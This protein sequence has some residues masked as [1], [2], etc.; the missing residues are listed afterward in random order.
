M[1]LV[2]SENIG[3]NQSELEIFVDANTFQNACRQAYLRQIKRLNIPGFRKGKAPKKVVEKLLG[4]QVFFESAIDMVYPK[5]VE[6]AIEEAGL[7]VVSL[8]KIEPI[9]MSEQDGLN[10]KATC[11]LKPEAEIEN[12]KGIEVEVEPAKEVDDVEVNKQIEILRERG[13]R[14]ISVSDRGAKEGDMVLIDY[15]GFIDGSKFKGGSAK[16][17][18]LKLGSKQFIEGFEK[19]IEGHKVGE[20]FDI[21]VVFPSDY[22]VSE[23]KE[24]KAVFK[25]KL[26]EIKFL[27]L[28]DVDDEF[29]KDVS[30]FDT[31]S[32]LREDIKTRLQNMINQQRNSLIEN[33]V[34]RFL[35]TNVKVQIPNVMIKNRTDELAKHFEN[36]LSS[37]GVSLEQYLYI[38]RTSGFDLESDFQVRAELEIRSDLALEKIAKLENLEVSESDIDSEREKI[39]DVY[40]IKIDH[41]KKMFPSQSLRPRLILQKALEFVKNNVKIVNIDIKNKNENKENINENKEKVKSSSDVDV[42]KPVTKTKKRATST[43]IDGKKKA[44]L[45]KGEEVKIN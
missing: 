28:P 8:E 33:R 17:Y 45:K 38:T 27:Q 44:G 26:N 10:F 12:Y 14:L 20:L 35:A 42:K 9:T 34:L 21:E 24:K 22:R 39:A 43:K 40:K 7:D 23:L 37:R 41:V 16:N 30:K 6:E 18:S 36:D 32:E 1:S 4:P 3:V 29:V 25:C 19:Q 31:L 2:K 13:G 5:A 11:I 15:E